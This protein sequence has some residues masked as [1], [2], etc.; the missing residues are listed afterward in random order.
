MIKSIAKAIEILNL[1]S[2]EEPRLTLGEIS[3]RLNLPKTTVHNLLTTLAHYSLV[4]RTDD[5]RYALGTALIPMTQA[6]RVNVELRDRAAPLLRKLADA[7]RES[8]YLTVRDG[9]HA[10]YIYAVESPRR[11]LARTA[12]GERVLLHC[13]A[14]GKA[15]LAALPPAEIEVF[16]ERQGLPAFTDL[17]IT[18][19]DAL[20][21]ELTLTRERGFAIDRGEHEEGTYC[22]GA[23][24]FDRQGCVLGACSVSGTDPEIIGQRLP[25]LS[26]QVMHVA[27]EISRRMGYVRRS[28]SALPE[29]L[30]R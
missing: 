22:V 24:I 18:Q 8:V 29:V 25:E 17:T 7:C 13:T 23:A 27:D 4:E 10:L 3:A 12:I 5:G 16:M 2:P 28:L 15:I 20:L 9:D 1:F 14:V 11:L 19:P 21:G 30:R 6:V 26:A